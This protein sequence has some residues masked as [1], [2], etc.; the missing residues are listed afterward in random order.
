MDEQAI[1]EAV[2]KLMYANLRRGHSKFLKKDYCYIQPSPNKYPFQWFWDSFFHIIILCSLNE[3]EL[4]KENLES[5]FSRQEEDGFVGHMIYWKSLLPPS[6]WQILE[7]HPTFEQLRPHM[8]AMIQP[9]F[10]A[11]CLE[12]IYSDTKDASFLKKMLP[13]IKRYHE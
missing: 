11:Q 4:A 1:R 13:K 5:L 8:S 7:A 3:Q 9:T 6:I 10:A 12:R 2:R